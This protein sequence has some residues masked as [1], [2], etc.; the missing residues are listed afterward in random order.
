[1]KM[2]NLLVSTAAFSSFCI[3]NNPAFAAPMANTFQGTGAGSS[4]TTGDDNS[5]FGFNALFSN[6]TAN[7]NTAVGADALYANTGNLNTGCG[8]GALANNTT[9]NEN[10]ALGAVALGGVTTGGDN[11]GLGKNGGVSITTGSLNICIGDSGSSSDNKTIRIGTQGTQTNTLIAGI[12]GTTI[13]SGAAVYV[14]SSGQLGT[15]TSSARFKKDIK[16]MDDASD[17]ILSLH[18][19]TFRYKSDLDPQGIPQFG[20]VAEEVAKVDP[21]LVVRDD[22]NQSYTV[23]YQAVDAMLLNEFLKQHQTVEEQKTEIATLKEKAAKV[24]LL[25]ER[26]NNLAKTVQ[27]LTEKD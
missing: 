3:V 17:V 18:P 25:E 2:K 4:N 14:N 1:M 22:K 5:A 10:T 9:G 20:L 16:S 7:N 23:R 21:S 19:V 8:L 11:I 27:S 13:A 24:E 6:T 12:Y 26:L 15:M